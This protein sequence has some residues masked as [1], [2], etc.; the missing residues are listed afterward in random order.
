MRKAKISPESVGAPMDRGSRPLG[1]RKQRRIATSSDG[2]HP[3]SDGLQ[4][5]SDG[6]D[7]VASLLLVVILCY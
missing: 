1:H 4:P 7:L 5:N 2:L 6:L 3:N